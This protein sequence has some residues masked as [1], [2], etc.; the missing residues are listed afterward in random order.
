MVVQENELPINCLY[1]L[2]KILFMI[3]ECVRALCLYA[4]RLY[5]K[6][7]MSI[8]FFTVVFKQVFISAFLRMIN[9]ME[10]MLLF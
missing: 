9:Y 5:I 4:S 3:L 2:I 8:K 6:D 1:P 7:E 10:N